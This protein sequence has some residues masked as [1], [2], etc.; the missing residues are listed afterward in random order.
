MNNS[1]FFCVSYYE[2]DLAW[3]PELSKGNYIVYTKRPIDTDKIDKNKIIQLPNVGYNIHS[4]FTYIVDNYESLPDYIVF[5]KSNVFP[6]HV[7]KDLFYE[8]SLRKVFTPIE[9]PSRW[10]NI[11]PIS[12]LSSDNGYL[13][14][15]NNWYF[16]QYNYKYFRNFDAFFTFIFDCKRA[17]RYLRFAPGANYVVP[18][19]NILLR[20]KNFYL[21]LLRLTE[22]SQ[23]PCESHM[24]E[25]AL[26]SIWN[27][28][29]KESTRMSSLISDFDLACLAN[30]VDR[31]KLARFK[32]FQTYIRSR[33]NSKLT[34]YI[35]KIFPFK[36]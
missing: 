34:E 5:C 11:Y 8:L 13:E 23:L 20:S 4:Y 25:R 1:H 27:S 14:L 32:F 16:R 7:S 19:Q 28:T 26:Y 30:S 31:S 33:I 17:P 6:R 9:D 29:L 2:G 10:K 35:D 21:N 3:L 18:K 24:I 22:Y 15:N 36:M 12:I